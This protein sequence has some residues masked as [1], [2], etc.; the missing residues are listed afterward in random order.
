MKEPINPKRGLA[1]FEETVREFSVAVAESKT[2]AA[3]REYNQPSAD[4]TQDPAA[5]REAIEELRAHQEELAVAD[6]EIRSQLAELAATTEA[7]HAERDRYCELFDAAPDAYFLTDTKAVVRD[8]NAATVA[9]LGIGAS[10]LRGKPLVALVDAGDVREFRDAVERLRSEATVEIE[11]RLKPRN[12]GPRWH[13]LA[14][15]RVE[16]DTAILWIARDVHD[17]RLLSERLTQ[18]NNGLEALASARLLELERANRDKEEILRRERRLR[19]E[20]EAANAAKDRFL[21]VLSHDLRAP[22][23]A[24]IGWT[25]LMRREKLGQDARDRALATIER[26]AAAQLRLV[27]ELLDISRLTSES[28]QLERTSLDLGEIVRRAVETVTPAAEERGLELTADVPGEPL[29]LAGDRRRL[30]Q[31]MTN[32][33]SNAMKFTPSGGRISLAVTQDGARARVTVTDTG[34]GIERELQGRIFDAFRQVGDYT[35]AHRGFG[36]GLYIVRQAVELHGGTVTATSEGLGRGSTFTVVLPISTPAT[37]KVRA[38]V[39][40][41]GSLMGKSAPRLDGVRVLVVDDEDDARELMTAVL[42][43]RGALVSTASDV[44]SALRA[45]DA[46]APDVVLSDIAMPDRGGGE[47]IRELRKRSARC[48]YVAVSG[49]ASAADVGRALA[50]GFD[51]HLAKPVSP[52]ELVDAVAGAARRFDAAAGSWSRG[53]APQP[54]RD[55]AD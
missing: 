15:R 14:A 41:S 4:L 35:T 10:Y 45:F 36:L 51:Q 24:V 33:L 1:S 32:L 11:V 17:R 19:I 13:G 26:N 28:P 7:A 52:G 29:L 40:S 3:T 22:L 49:Y 2:R 47:L 34:A 37:A 16:Q 18:S 12:G 23:N 55:P 48:T 38:P 25:Q 42:R 31:V 20:H 39:S 30:E 8:V 27:E 53:E 44:A 54:R 43:Q 5:L 6:E 50:A 9:A 46:D 21:A